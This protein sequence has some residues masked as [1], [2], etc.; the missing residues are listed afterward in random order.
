MILKYFNSNFFRITQIFCVIYV[1]FIWLDLFFFSSALPVN[2]ILSL[3]MLSCL[4][5]VANKTRAKAYIFRN[6]NYKNKFPKV[7]KS[8]ERW[9]MNALKHEKGNEQG[10]GG[11]LSVRSLNLLL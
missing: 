4:S 8:I 3:T 10:V 7:V 1:R 6:A 2:F 9:V 5:D 11:N